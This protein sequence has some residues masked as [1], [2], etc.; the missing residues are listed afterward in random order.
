MKPYDS[1]GV[2]ADLVAERQ[3]ISDTMRR[4]M[5]A[6]TELL[7]AIADLENG[8]LIGAAGGIAMA[9]EHAPELEHLDLLFTIIDNQIQ[10]DTP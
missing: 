4:L 1:A 2:I 6:N 3:R 5:A 8:D 9:Q 10:K 7:E